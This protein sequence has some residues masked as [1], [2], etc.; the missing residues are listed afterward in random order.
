MIDFAFKAGRVRVIMGGRCIP[1]WGAPTFSGDGG[2]GGCQG[3]LTTEPEDMLEPQGCIPR[4][5]VVSSQVRY[6]WTRQWHLHNSH[7]T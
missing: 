1:P 3:A 5:P 7:R 2:W 4:D 6:D